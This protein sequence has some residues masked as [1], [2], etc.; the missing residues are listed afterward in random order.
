MVT[1]L[2]S[3]I[4]YKI[5]LNRLWSLICISYLFIFLIDLMVPFYSKR[6][7]IL[8]SSIQGHCRFPQCIIYRFCSLNVPTSICITIC[9]LHYQVD[10]QE[11]VLCQCNIRRFEFVVLHP[12]QMVLFF[13]KNGKNASSCS[14]EHH[15]FKF[16][17]YIELKTWRYCGVFSNSNR[18]E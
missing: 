15:L 5:L 17:F 14:L 11:E 18:S 1:R 10:Q 8:S 7:H 16:S 2:L 6:Q 12:S 9:I 13:L 4:V 3:V